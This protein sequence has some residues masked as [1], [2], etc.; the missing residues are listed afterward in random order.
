MSSSQTAAFA[1]DAKAVASVAAHARSPSA[2]LADLPLSL[3]AG[4]V[5]RGASEADFET[6]HADG[7]FVH[8]IVFV[9]GQ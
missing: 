1:D 7:L 3:I 5:C 9:M 2:S 6:L 8:P 4:R